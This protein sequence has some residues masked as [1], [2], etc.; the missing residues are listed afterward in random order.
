[1][2]I[3]YEPVGGS[4]YTT[5]VDESLGT[6]VVVD[7]K[8]KGAIAVQRE[9]LAVLAGAANSTFR[10][11]MGNVTQTL[12]ITILITYANRGA[13]LVGIQTLTTALLTVKNNL[14][15]NESTGTA[16]TLYY[17]NAVC[18][19]LD[20]DLTGVTVLY[21]MNFESDLVLTPPATV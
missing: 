15:V 18:T 2:K 13:A 1:M 17:P 12:P 3:S 11:P 7:W 6:N 14:Q 4:G 10:Q 20:A 16:T 9:P 5:L 21:K 8:P 19:S